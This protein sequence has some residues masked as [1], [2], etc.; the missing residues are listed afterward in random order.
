M[1]YFIHRY[2]YDKNPEQPIFLSKDN[3]RENLYQ[4][5]FKAKPASMTNRH[6]YDPDHSFHELGIKEND[7]IIVE[8]YFANVEIGNNKSQENGEDKRIETLDVL[9]SETEKTKNNEESL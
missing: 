1:H 8:R 9:D 4:W 2:N 5:L 7:S 3:S 6:I